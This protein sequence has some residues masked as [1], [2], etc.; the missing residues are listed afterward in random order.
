MITGPESTGKTELSK[1]LA[2]FF[3]TVWVPEYAREYIDKLGRPYV[4]DDILK[5]AERQLENEQKLKGK[6][7]QFLFADTSMLVAKIWSEFVFGSCDPWIEEK[8]HTHKYDLY[9]L[10]DIDM[11]W[12]YDPQREH[13]EARQELFNLYH[14]EL[15]KHGFPFVIISGLGEQRL[16]NA[17][18]AVTRHFNI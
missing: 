8:L 1:G 12:E 7:H 3:N 11:P 4:Q 14:Q 2:G 13:P 15:K 10:C 17:I 6:A 9:L 5:I 18:S 16:K